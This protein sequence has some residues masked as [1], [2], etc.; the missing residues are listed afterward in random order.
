MNG[1]AIV[2]MACTYGGASTPA[3]L[4][5]NA[6]S[7]RRAFRRIPAERLDLADYLG[8][9]GTDPDRISVTHA[10]VLE[11]Y[12]FDRAAFG[13]AGPTYR[14]TDLT[15]WL[16]LDTASRALSDAGLDATAGAADTSVFVGNTLTGEFTRS[17]VLRTRWPYVRRVVAGLLADLRDRFLEPFPEP[18]GDTLAG[19][20]SNTIAGR[21]CSHFGF[22]G[23]GYT[24]D[25]ACASSLLA[26]IH[27]C[28]EI[29]EG[30]ARTVVA[31][32]VDL[33]IDPFELVGFSRAGALARDRMRVFDRG[34]SGFLPG[35]GCGMVVLTRLEDAQALGLRPYAVLRG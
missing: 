27:G 28:R 23:G 24:V 22:G 10:A 25:G 30:R 9:S 26:V 12:E 13:V 18:D 31:G 17:H 11:G 8:E 29:T 2:G 6:L 7:G 15:H 20:L 33:S 14:A 1:V 21:I 4:W 5:D 34:S 32:G 16:A 19:S 3:E 35:E